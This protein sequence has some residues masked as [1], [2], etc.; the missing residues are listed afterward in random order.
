MTALTHPF[1]PLYD[2]NSRILVLGSFPSVASRAVNFFYGHPRNRFWQLLADWAGE[3]LPCDTEGRRALALRHGIAM[4]DVLA[5]CEIEG[6]SDASVRNAVPN[7]LSPIFA[8]AEIRTVLC[9][10]SLSKSVYDRYLFQKTGIPALAMPSTSP[11]NAAW[12]L[13]K[14]KSVWYPALDTGKDDHVS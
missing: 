5:S 6:S 3:P 11:A 4:W 10:G 1:P 2:G 8:A 12:S 13:E 9:N 7:D 14:L